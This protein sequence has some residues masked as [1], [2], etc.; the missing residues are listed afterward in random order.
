MARP[1]T[2][3][4]PTAHQLRRIHRCL[5]A[6]LQ[7]WQR[8][9][10]EALLL[11]AAGHTAVF[12]AR[13]LDAHVNTIYADLQAFARHGLRCLQPTRRRG[14][15]SRLT[16]A[17][18]KAI[19]RLA[20]QSPLGPRLAVRPLVAGQTPC[21]PDPAASGEGHQPRAP[22]Q[23][24]QKRGFSSAS[25]ASQTSRAHDPQRRA[26]LRRL[27]GF[28]QHR[29]RGSLLAFFDVQPITVKAYGGRR[30]TREAQLILSAKQ[31]TRGRFYLFA[32]YEV[33]HGRVRWAFFAGKGA[34]TSAGSCAGSGV[35]IPR[36][37]CGSL[38][39][40]TRPTRAKRSKPSI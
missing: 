28:W 20:E 19:W 31:K 10:A 12:I 24:A 29:R 13:L 1:L 40:K 32:L 7:P 22:A 37:R 30:Y 38:W 15:P 14:A 16:P 2:V 6:P 3:R 21:L 34:G 8:R 17:Q 18:L 9:R 36:N 33:N 39:I 5:E 4:P 25:G 11:L 27:K 23:G 35:G 26:I